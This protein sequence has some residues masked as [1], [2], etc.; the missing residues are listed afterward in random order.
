MQLVG[1]GRKEDITLGTVGAK[2]QLIEG[3]GVD[4]SP[5]LETMNIIIFVP[6]FRK[7]KITSR[8]VWVFISMLSANTFSGIV[9]HYCMNYLAGA[10]IP[11]KKKHSA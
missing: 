6:L 2:E 11:D 10:R 5:S 3:F 7:E 1:E 4:Q 8:V 9:A